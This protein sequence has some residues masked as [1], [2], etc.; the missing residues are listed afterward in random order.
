MTKWS[1]WSHIGFKKYRF[2]TLKINWDAVTSLIFALGIY[3]KSLFADILL[4]S[5]FALFLGI[6]EDLFLKSKT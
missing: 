2:K 3:G 1:Q 5:F 4:A 6:R